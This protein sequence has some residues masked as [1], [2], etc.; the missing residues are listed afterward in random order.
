MKTQ[1]WKI[2]YN[3]QY[4][5]TNPHLRYNFDTSLS[6][7]KKPTR[8][9]SLGKSRNRNRRLKHA[10]EFLVTFNAHDFHTKAF[11]DLSHTKW[12]VY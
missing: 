3:S 1:E 8:E 7:T 6:K 2:S 9:A 5:Y 11:I 4:M 12:F 10:C